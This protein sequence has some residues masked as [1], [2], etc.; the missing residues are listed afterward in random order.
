[1][2]ISILSKRQAYFSVNIIEN[3]ANAYFPYY[4]LKYSKLNL[5]FS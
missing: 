5:F 2:N 1:M 4:F 3:G